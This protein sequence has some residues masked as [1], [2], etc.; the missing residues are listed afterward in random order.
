MENVLE[1]KRQVKNVSIDGEVYELRKPTVMQV[2]EFRLNSAKDNDDGE[3]LTLDLLEACGIRRDVLETLDLEVI[4]LL[5][6]QIL[7]KKKK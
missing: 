2:R 7:P 1:I 4:T 5:M 6:E 3:I